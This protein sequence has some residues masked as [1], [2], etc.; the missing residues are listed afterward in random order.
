MLEYSTNKFGK[1]RRV[2]AHSVQLPDGR[3]ANDLDQWALAAELKKMKCPR[4][5]E[6]MGKPD[7]ILLLGI[8]QQELLEEKRA[9]QQ[10]GK[11]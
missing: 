1:W 7:L 5:T 4:V 2:D 3:L 10:N 9:G 11:S 6:G 8:H